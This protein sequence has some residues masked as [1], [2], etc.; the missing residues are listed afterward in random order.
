MYP[1]VGA[2]NTSESKESLTR[3]KSI[4][5]ESQTKFERIYLTN[6]FLQQLLIHFKQQKNISVN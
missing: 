1:T 3:F 5:N 6:E 4:N 2:K